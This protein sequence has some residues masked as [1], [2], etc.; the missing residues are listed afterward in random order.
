M[1]NLILLLSEVQ[2]NFC[3]EV[4]DSVEAQCS[5][6]IAE[7]HFHTKLKHNLTP[8]IK[9]EIFTTHFLQFLAEKE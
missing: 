5:S 9:S 4:F 3:N 8:A 2:H 6:T 1:R 7:R